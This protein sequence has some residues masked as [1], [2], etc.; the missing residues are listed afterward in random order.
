MNREDKPIRSYHHLLNRFFTVINHIRIF[1]N[2][3][4][5]V[6]ARWVFTLSGLIS[7]SILILEFGFYYP[8]EWNPFIRFAIL[9]VVYYLV[10]Y[11]FVSFLFT[12]EGYKGHLKNRKIEALIVILVILQRIL[13]EDIAIFFDL[14]PHSGDR[15]ALLFLSVS[16][17]MLMINLVIH[18]VRTA[19]TSGFFKMNPSLIFLGSFA[20]VILV[21]TS[22]LSMPRSIK[23]EMS[24]V[25]L[26]F[27]SVSATCVTGL[28]PVDISRSFTGSGQLVL[29][30]LIQVGGLGLMTL[31]SFFAYFLTGRASVQTGLLMR[32]LLSEDSLGEVRRLIKDIAIMTFGIEGAGAVFLFFTTPG[33]MHESVGE[34]IF[35]SVFHSVSAFCNAGFSLYPDSMM[36]MNLN[37]RFYQTGIMILIVLGGLGF[38]VVSQA[39]KKFRNPSDHR[40]RLS[41]ATRIV[42]WVNLFLYV[43]GFSAYFILESSSSLSGHNFPD[44]LF[45]SLFYSVTTRT[46]G[47][48]T[49]DMESLGMPMIFFSFLLMWIG[50]SPASTGGGIKTSTFAV[51]VIHVINYLMG[52]DRVEIYKKTVSPASVHRAYSS[53][54]LSLMVI[55][56]SIFLMVIIES[57]K[58]FLNIA[59]EAVSA[60]GTVGLS[61]GMTGDLESSSKVILSFLMLMGRVG[62]LTFLVAL[63]P[64]KRQENY[65]YPDEYVIVG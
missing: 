13:E 40:I 31:T 5:R 19:Q 50:A 39:I 62:V 16:Q 28:S 55:F 4:V 8:E 51:V 60:F 64:R 43:A 11:E 35:H 52:R 34:R 56:I 63:L 46:A 41:V 15:A 23:S 57:K 14:D 24:P 22:L 25:D 33:W 53:V 65:R 45:H 44:R 36:S 30:T 47:F 58:S 27:I 10:I 6:I 18:F 1:Y 48:N 42:L 59:F 2:T 7:L 32:D 21:G 17:G 37:G 9:A 29:L 12:S 3:R 20:L 54:I 61:M 38:P 26:F 49:L